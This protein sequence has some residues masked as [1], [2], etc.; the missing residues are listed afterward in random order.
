ME[1][2]SHYQNRVTIIYRYLSKNG[3]LLYDKWIKV[4][5]QV[6]ISIEFN[7]YVKIV[8]DRLQI[9]ISKNFEV[10]NIDFCFIQ[11]SPMY[12][13]I[14]IRLRKITYVLSVKWH[15]KHLFY[16]CV[17]TQSIWTRIV[18]LLEVSSLTYPQVF[19]C[20]V[21]S[22]PRHVAN[23][24]VL[25]VKRYVYVSRC[26]NDRLSFENCVNEIRHYKEIEY[27]I[28]QKKG[29]PCTHEIKWSDVSL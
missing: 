5:K 4:R 11:L 26:M 27:E 6:D 25:I 16:D 2:W 8:K 14:H 19:F 23:C 7:D 1:E 9:T 20:N 10:F 15:Q 13:Y 12:S 3:D 22:N 24:I 28:A 17:K 18:K 29:K 21:T